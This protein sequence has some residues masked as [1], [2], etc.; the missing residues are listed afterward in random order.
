[1]ATSRKTT[2]E[3]DEKKRRKNTMKKETIREGP[4]VDVQGDNIK[5][6]TGRQAK[7]KSTAKVE[8][9]NE[10]DRR[11]GRRGINNFH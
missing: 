3:R 7:Q 1:L 8:E 11:G 4:Q 10:G 9:K 5:N 6:R 2:K